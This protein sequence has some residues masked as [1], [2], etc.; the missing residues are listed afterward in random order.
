MGETFWGAVW[1]FLIAFWLG[2]EWSKRKRCR[3][4]CEFHTRT[5]KWPTWR[6]LD[7]YN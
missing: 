2:A 1:I 5:G 4:E 3:Q 6:D 7:H